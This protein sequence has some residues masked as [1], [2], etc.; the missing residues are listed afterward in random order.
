MAYSLIF[1]FVDDLTTE[2][3][4]NAR[5]TVEGF[6]FKAFAMSV[7]VIWLYLFC[8]MLVLNQIEHLIISFNLFIPRGVLG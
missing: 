2:L 6:I 5:D 7:I 8:S 4:D 3:S 1:F